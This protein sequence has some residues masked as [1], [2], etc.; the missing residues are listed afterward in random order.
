[1]VWSMVSRVARA[2]VLSPA[3]TSF[4]NTTSSEILA[5][6][7][8]HLE[9]VFASPA[10]KTSLAPQESSRKLYCTHTRSPRFAENVPTGQ[11][12]Q[13][14]SERDVPGTTFVP[15]SHVVAEENGLHISALFIAEKDPFVQETQLA[16]SK[17]ADPALYPRPVP[18]DNTDLDAQAVL[19]RE[20]EYFPS[21]HEVQEV[22]STS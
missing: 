20:V 21:A 5:S 4:F 1:M 19:P 16:S 11:D 18:Q 9:S 17:M 6:S 3:S 7:T 22:Q 14:T 15:G 10:T 13:A 12:S 2:A 8:R